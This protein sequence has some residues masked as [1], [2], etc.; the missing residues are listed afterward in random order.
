MLKSAFR[1]LDT[2]NTGTLNL[3]EMRQAFSTAQMTEAEL[4]EIFGRLDFNKDN[5][6]NYS[7]FLAATVM[8]TKVV[9]DSNLKLAFHH[10]DVDNTGY[11]TAAN[12]AQA[13]KRQGKNYSDEDVEAMIGQVEH[14]NTKGKVTYSEFRR[15][16][17]G[18]LD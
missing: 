3:T 6:I 14:C 11:I 16:M 18:I 9:T 5:E 12:L 15:L 4:N 1:Q 13:F 10:F 7:E 2:H 8:K 17:M